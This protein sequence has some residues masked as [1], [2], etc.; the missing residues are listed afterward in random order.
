MTPSHR[1]A[2]TATA[3]HGGLGRARGAGRTLPVADVHIVDDGSG[4]LGCERAA[5]FEGAR[6]RVLAQR[7]A[8]ASRHSAS[9][10]AM[11]NPSSLSR[12]ARS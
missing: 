4:L 1:R 5:A 7:R 3:A 12:I 2:T 10:L 9:S 6:E 8:A 11:R